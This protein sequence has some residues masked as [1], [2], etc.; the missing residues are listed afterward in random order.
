MEEIPMQEEVLA[1]TFFLNENPIIIFFILEH[2]MI[3]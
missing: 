3:L 2:Q 1:G